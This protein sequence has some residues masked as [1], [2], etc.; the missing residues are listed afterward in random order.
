MDYQ[1]KRV[2]EWQFRPFERV[3]IASFLGWKK[4][5]TGFRYFIDGREVDRNGQN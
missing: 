1:I 4:V 2:T 3:G 5:V